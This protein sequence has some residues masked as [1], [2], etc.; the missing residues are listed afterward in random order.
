MNSVTQGGRFSLRALT[1]GTPDSDSFT[2]LAQQLRLACPHSL[3]V[4]E[5]GLVRR[6]STSSLSQMCSFPAKRQSLA[7]AGRNFGVDVSENHS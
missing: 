2:R 6:N 4:P 1:A 5:Q 3:Q 7:P